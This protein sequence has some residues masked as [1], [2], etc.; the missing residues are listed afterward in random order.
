MVVAV[1]SVL[2]HLSISEGADKMRACPHPPADTS[3]G[4]RL[5][6]PDRHWMP[7]PRACIPL[8]AQGQ[9]GCQTV[10]APPVMAPWADEMQTFRNTGQRVPA[11]TSLSHPA[12]LNPIPVFVQT[13][14]EQLHYSV[15]RQ[16]NSIDFAVPE[17]N[18]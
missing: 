1:T 7:L 9:Q 6:P 3:T 11:Y 13:L 17:W 15:Y 18:S 8:P 14:T 4:G 12:T 5:P 16:R 2:L 10:P